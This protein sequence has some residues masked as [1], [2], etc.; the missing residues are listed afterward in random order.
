[1]H[2]RQRVVGG[3]LALALLGSGCMGSFSLTRKL[4]HWNQGVSQD[5]WGREFVFL[6]LVLIP[7]YDLAGVGDAIVFNSIEFWTG[8]N[9]I[10]TARAPKIKRLTYRDTEVVLSQRQ[11]VAGLELSIEQLRN[12]RSISRVRLARQGGV[13]VASDAQGNTRFIAQTLPDGS[14]LITNA[15]GQQVALYSPQDIER[16]IASVHH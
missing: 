12:G 4:Y 7:I 2:T 14:V 5:R 1:M 8:K 13:S 10:E 11:G 16:V 3:L 15:D 6:I 9:P